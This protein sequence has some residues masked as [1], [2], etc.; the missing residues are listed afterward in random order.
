MDHFE[1]FQL[2]DEC[3][4]GLM[5]DQFRDVEGLARFAQQIIQR[6]EVAVFD[7]LPQPCARAIEAEVEQRVEIQQ[8]ARAI[9]KRREYGAG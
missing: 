8:H 4:D 6:D 7:L 2:L 9:G 3:A 5:R 1:L